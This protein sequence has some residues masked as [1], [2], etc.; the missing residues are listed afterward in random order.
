MCQVIEYARHHKHLFNDGLSLTV[1]DMPSLTGAIHTVR[2]TDR[3]LTA[4]RKM[5]DAG[6]SLAFIVQL[7]HGSSL[8]RCVCSP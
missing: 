6:T 1:Q 3:P 7:S 4:F 5:T 8:S 2:D